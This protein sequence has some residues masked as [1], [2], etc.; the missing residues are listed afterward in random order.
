MRNFLRKSRN[1]LHHGVFLLPVGHMML[2]LF[3]PHVRRRLVLEWRGNRLAQADS[4]WREDVVALRRIPF[5]FVSQRGRPAVIG[6]WPII[7]AFLWEKL[8]YLA[9]VGRKIAA[10]ELVDWP[11]LDRLK[12]VGLKQR[13]IDY[14]ADAFK[15]Y[16]VLL[17]SSHGDFHL[18]NVVFFDKQLALIDWSLY[19][20]KSTFLIDLLHLPLRRICTEQRLSWTEALFVDMPEWQRIGQDTTELKLLRLLYAVDR[21]SREIEQKGGVDRVRVEKYIRPLGRLTG[22]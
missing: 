21:A 11:L 4:L 9:A 1:R 19:R 13:S 16:D 14:V 17:S 2:K 18:D 6:D 7:Q 5:G 10:G 20:S 3:L 12:E 15:D 8:D 22:Q